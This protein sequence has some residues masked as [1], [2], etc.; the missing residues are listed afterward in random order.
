[1]NL[2]KTNLD[3]ISAS[4]IRPSDND[5][6]NRLFIKEINRIFSKRT[7]FW[8]YYDNI[9]GDY[10]LNFSHTET[11]VFYNSKGK[12]VKLI[13]PEEK[14]LFQGSLICTKAI[15]KKIMLKRFRFDKGTIIRLTK[16][17][18]RFK[19]KIIDEFCTYIIEFDNIIPNS[20]HY[21]NN[22]EKWFEKGKIFA[23]TDIASYQVV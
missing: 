13:W 12:K 19:V 9:N 23:F 2:F 15:C 17:K 4:L 8:N 20:F 22:E 21:I 6:S 14:T 1:M 5:E 7:H 18:D 11:Y 10:Y 3:S 16:K